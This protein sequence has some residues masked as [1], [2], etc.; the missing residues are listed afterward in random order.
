M[1]NPKRAQS[2]KRPRR[3]R[4]NL[5]NDEPV[6]YSTQGCPDTDVAAD[7]TDADIDAQ[8]PELRPDWPQ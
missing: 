6:L 7:A 8:T 3:P 5:K 4:V 2:W 1:E